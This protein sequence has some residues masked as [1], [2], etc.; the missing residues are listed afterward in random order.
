MPLQPSSIFEPLTLF[1]ALTANGVFSDKN[2]LVFAS[3]STLT[4]ASSNRNEE[5]FFELI[6]KQILAMQS[7]IEDRLTRVQPLR[8][9]CFDKL[10]EIAK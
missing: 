3:G 5:R 7:K 4:E 9:D 2:H 8:Q 6:G 1:Q 10:F